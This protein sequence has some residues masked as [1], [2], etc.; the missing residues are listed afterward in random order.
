MSTDQTSVRAGN[1][2]TRGIL[3]GLPA[4]ILALTLGVWLIT[5]LDLVDSFVTAILPGVLL[6]VFGGGFAGMA[7]NMD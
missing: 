7:A 5:D 2:I 3:I 1:A 4:V 6:G